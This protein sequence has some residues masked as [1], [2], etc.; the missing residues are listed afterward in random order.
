MRILYPLLLL[1]ILTFVVITMVS[2]QSDSDPKDTATKFLNSVQQADYKST[3]EMFGGNTCRCPKKG[4]WVSY[5]VYASAQEPNLAFAMGRPFEFGSMLVAPVTHPNKNQITLLPWQKPEDVIVDLDISFDEARYLPLFLPLKMAYG[6]PMQEA[7]FQDFITN[8]NKDC[9][10]GF[11]LRLRPSI[12]EGAIKRPDASKGIEYNPTE[13]AIDTNSS[14]SLS[15]EDKKRLL[16]KTLQQ[17]KGA[18]HELS[19]KEK[20]KK[21]DRVA[22]QPKTDLDEEENDDSFIYANIEDAIKETLGDEIAMYLHP[23]DAGIVR[24]KDGSTVPQEQVEKALPRLKSFKLRLHIVRREKLKKWTVY[25]FGFIQ[26]VVKLS[27]G[28]EVALS[29]YRNP[30]GEKIPEPGPEVE[31]K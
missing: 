10:Q 21:E 19:S 13:H 14:G 23:K 20:E 22:K 28:S 2:T 3:V 12:A 6:I 8:P 1:T 24:K 5:L 30:S 29:S 25:H 11:T 31:S 16:N 17:V 18:G 26:P 4:G 15:M 27:D 7:E 9:W